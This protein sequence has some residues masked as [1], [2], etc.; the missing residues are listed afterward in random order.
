MRPCGF[1]QNSDLS[2]GCGTGGSAVVEVEQYR[3]LALLNSAAKAAHT[4]P[5]WEFGMMIVTADGNIDPTTLASVEA[6]MTRLPGA[7]QI[8]S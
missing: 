1:D 4:A 2:H 3:T 5:T 7:K 6:D 8:S